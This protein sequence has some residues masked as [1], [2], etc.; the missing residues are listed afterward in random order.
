M[1][2]EPLGSGDFT[3]EAFGRLGPRATATHGGQAE[4][5]SV[6]QTLSVGTQLRSRGPWRCSPPAYSTAS[7]APH[8]DAERS[9]SKID[10][11]NSSTCRVAPTSARGPSA[12]TASRPST[13]ERT[14]SVQAS[15]RILPVHATFL[16]TPTTGTDLFPRPRRQRTP[17]SFWWYRCRSSQR[18]VSSP[19]HPSSWRRTSSFVFS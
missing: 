12:V 8:R 3:S 5:N 15:L 16:R 13:P 2:D 11:S 4:V 17:W 14:G 6:L 10:G 7:V 19:P 18:N 1:S 9:G